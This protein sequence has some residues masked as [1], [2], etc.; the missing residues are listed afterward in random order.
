MKRYGICCALVLLAAPLAR[1]HGQAEAPDRKLV[2]ETWHAAYFEGAKAGHVHT[3]VRELRRDGARLFLTSRE[4]HLAIKRYKEVVPVRLELTS[5][6]KP[7]GKTV[8]VSFTQFLAKD[9]KVSQSGRVEGGKLVVRSSAGGAPA[10]LP[11]DAD[12]VGLYHQDR[13]FQLRKV[14]PGDRF[15]FVGYELALRAPLTVRVAVKDFETTDVLVT[16]K[17]GKGQ[18]Q[19]TRQPARLLRVEVRPDK[20]EVGGTAVQLPAQVT[21][22]DDELM[23]VRQQSELPGLGKVTF[24]QTTREAAEKEGVAPDLLPDLGLNTVIAVKQNID[25]PYDT[26]SAVY[27][28]RLKGEEDPSVAFARDARQEA[29]NVKGDTYELHVKAIRAPAKAGKPAAAGKEYL[30]SSYFLD[31]DS[32]RVRA[33]AA[34]VTKG[35]SDP[36]R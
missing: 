16:R 27:R 12:A 4:L 19:V 29:L 22:L 7:D 1:A 10:R 20:V 26:R 24:Y 11:W 15:S 3:T 14:K 13:L 21:W 8:A 2:V 25:R 30:E 28:V 35:E 9:R 23:P 33:V 5:E 17:D 31:S 32:S 36:W 34:R 6:E 18:L